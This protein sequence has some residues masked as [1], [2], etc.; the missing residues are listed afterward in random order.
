MTSSER[1]R[2]AFIWVSIAL[3]V[4]MVVSLQRLRSASDAAADADE[5]GLIEERAVDRDARPSFGAVRMESE[6]AGKALVAVREFAPTVSP[7]LLL[8]QAEAMKQGGFTDQLAHAILV[9]K[10]RSWQEGIDAAKKLALPPQAEEDAGMLRDRVVQLMELRQTLEASD[11]AQGI[12]ARN[13]AE[14][15]RDKLGYFC[16]A[17]GPDAGV[18]AAT[19]L[20]ALCAAGAWYALAITSGLV[21]VALLA[22]RAIAGSLRPRFTPATSVHH[23]L[24]LG[25]TFLIWIAAYLALNVVAVVVIMPFADRLPSVAQPLVSAA[26]MLASLAVLVY[27]LRRGMGWNELRTSVGLHTGRGLFTEALCGITC[28]LTAVP[29]LACGLVLYGIVSY[30][31]QQLEGPAPAP[32]HPVVEMIGSAGAVEVFVL[33]LL[34][35]VV[36]PIVEETMFRGFLYGHLR[37]TVAPRIR[38]ASMIVAALV[39]SVVFA[40]IH[41]QGVLFVPALAGLAV[42]FCIHREIRGSLIAPI[43][44]HGINNAVTLM[45]A[46]TL[47]S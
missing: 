32:S 38:A 15:L 43:V 45:L 35:S 28:Y 26:M 37:G 21:V 25:E 17:L 44:A 31:V 10:V 2:R 33:L 4:V 40:V 3:I 41:P 12:G 47:L 5:G 20:I 11:D 39:S 27:P 8:E 1:F 16:D 36:A 13:A 18:K 34:A 29:L 19:T 42:G 30:I 9:G 7:D 6:L 46:L 23:A 24:V 14:P 22:F